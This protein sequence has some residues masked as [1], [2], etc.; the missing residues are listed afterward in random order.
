MSHI[1]NQLNN[2]TVPVWKA[3]LTGFKGDLSSEQI[4]KLRLWFNKQTKGVLT[5]E[6]HADGVRSHANLLIVK[7]Y[8]KNAFKRELF[9]EIYN[10][11]TREIPKWPRLVN[12][13]IVAKIDG[14]INYITKDDRQ[15]EQVEMIG[16]LRE[17][18]IERSNAHTKQKR[19]YCKLKY[20]PYCQAPYYLMEYC[21]NNNLTL[22]C[23]D[24]YASLI[25]RVRKHHKV[26]TA[27][28]QK[29]HEWI[30]GVIE[31]DM[32]DNESLEKQL[33]LNEL[34]FL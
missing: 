33:V 19:S 23:Q 11:P 10:L 5:F 18:L 17:D 2:T 8:K 20:I 31:T 14:W 29:R 4:V 13:G 32:N 12:I 27:K 3:V 30:M 16:F 25:V 26:D 15:M 9:R 22:T 21:K 7:D 28:W 1:E 34:R 6:K 24:D